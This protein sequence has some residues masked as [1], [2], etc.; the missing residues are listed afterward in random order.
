M[1]Y[2]DISPL[3]REFLGARE[4]FRRL[5]FLPDDLYIMTAKSALNGG[6]LSAFCQLKTQGK[7]FNVELGPLPSDENGFIAEYKRVVKAIVDGEVSEPVLQRIW[8]ESMPCQDKLGFIM[9]IQDKG[10]RVVKDAN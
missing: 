9:A 5:G 7:T 8:E 6:K 3:I 2:D 10:I 4:A 1:T